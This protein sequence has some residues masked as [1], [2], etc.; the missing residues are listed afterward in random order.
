MLYYHFGQFLGSPN[1]LSTFRLGILYIRYIIYKINEQII[2]LL[3]YLFIFS[4]ILQFNII[5]K[6]WFSITT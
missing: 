5:L 2:T 3:D 1:K 4:C 6:P